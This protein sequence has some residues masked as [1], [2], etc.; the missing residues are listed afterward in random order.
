[1]TLTRLGAGALEYRHADGT[2]V[3]VDRHAVQTFLIAIRDAIT[4]IGHVAPLNGVP[5]VSSA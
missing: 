1:V 3:L 4:W 5:P 2:T